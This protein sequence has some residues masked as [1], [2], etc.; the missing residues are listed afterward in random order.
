MN[1]ELV[2]RAHSYSSAS[3]QK[4]SESDVLDRMILMMVN[5]AI[6]CLSENI[7]ENN[8]LL[9]MAM[10]LGTGFPPFRGGLLKYA[11]SIGLKEVATR[12]RDLSSEYGDR[13]R[14]ADL[15][16]EYAQDG[17]TFY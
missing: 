6:R 8:V 4:K 7:V 16:I 1:R 13:F 10:I 2:S 9:D 14:P 5:E 12:L 3:H 11:D 15:L 17:K